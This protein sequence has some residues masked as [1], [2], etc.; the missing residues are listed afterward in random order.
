MYYRPTSAATVFAI[1]LPDDRDRVKVTLLLP[2]GDWTRG[3]SLEAEVV[4]SRTS[5]SLCVPLSA[6]HS[7]NSG[8]FVYTVTEKSTVLGIEN[9]LTQVPVNLSARDDT[10]AAIEGA[11]GRGDA[12]VTASNKSI[13]DGSRVRVN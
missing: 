4:I 1:A 3:Q 8:Y 7:D 13:G 2:E 12:V 6:L 11:L 9:V 10:N 5:Y